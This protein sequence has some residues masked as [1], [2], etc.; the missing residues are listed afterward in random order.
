MCCNWVHVSSG[1]HVDSW[2]VSA[3][4]RTNFDVVAFI[5]FDILRILGP[6]GIL[7]NYSNTSFT[8]VVAQNN[9]SRFPIFLLRFSSK[10]RH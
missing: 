9:F 4:K 1:N 3:A 5:I 2:H 6:R 10:F 7:Q 8:I